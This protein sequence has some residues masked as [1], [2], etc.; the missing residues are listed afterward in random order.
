VIGR[1]LS[2]PR[3]TSAH[4]SHLD[5]LPITVAPFIVS[6]PSSVSMYESGDFLDVPSPITCTL[7]LS[8][9]PESNAQQD[10]TTLRATS[11]LNSHVTCISPSARHSLFLITGAIAQASDETTTVLTIVS[12]FQSLPVVSFRPGTW[13]LLVP[14]T[15]RAQ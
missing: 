14:I 7:T 3:N 8:Y 5:S 9:P 6:Q 11:N 15:S 2:T 12:D 4:F 13:L 10:R 1:D